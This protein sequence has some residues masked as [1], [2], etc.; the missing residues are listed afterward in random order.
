[1]KKTLMFILLAS[2]A[3]NKGP[4]INPLLVGI[5]SQ[6]ATTDPPGIQVNTSPEYRPTLIFTKKGS[7]SGIQGCGCLFAQ[8]Y[9]QQGNHLE[10]TYGGT[11]CP[12][13]IACQPEPET[14]IISLTAEEL[15]LKRGQWQIRYERK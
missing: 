4:E 1:M 15:I 10:F 13:L 9:K 6:V 12:T 7:V 14:E 3:C 8:Q 5:W 11:P 2:I